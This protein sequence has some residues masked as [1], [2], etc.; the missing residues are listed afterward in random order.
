MAERFLDE[1]HHS[2]RP[3]VELPRG[4]RKDPPAQRS[5]ASPAKAIGLERFARAVVLVAI[6]LDG[7]LRFRV[8]EVDAPGLSAMPSRT[9]AISPLNPYDS[10]RIAA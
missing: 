4:D 9:L 10:R 6:A 2:R 5:E 3:L 8:R 7:D 1:L